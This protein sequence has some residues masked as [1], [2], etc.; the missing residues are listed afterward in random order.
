[1]SFRHML[2]AIDFSPT[3]DRVLQRALDL[4]RSTRS[5][6]TLLHVV[7]YLPPLGFADDFTPSPAVMIDEQNLVES[8]T[9]TLDRYCERFGLGEG[10]ARVVRVGMPRQEI[11]KLAAERGVDLIVIGSHGRHGLRRLLGSTANAVLND[12]T[13]DVLAIRSND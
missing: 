13:C 6:I 7:D 8:A 11:V 3:A 5:T 4:A 9:R 10:I 1:M 12:A 2:I